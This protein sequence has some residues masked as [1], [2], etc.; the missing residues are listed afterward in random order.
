MPH[1]RA[2]RTATVPCHCAALSFFSKRDSLI[3]WLSLRGHVWL[4]STNHVTWLPG[5]ALYFTDESIL[6]LLLDYFSVAQVY[7]LMLVGH[8][9]WNLSYSNKIVL[10]TGQCCRR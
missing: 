6:I 7:E 9:L 10:I 2:L 5:A 1:R 3:H 8:K 4:T